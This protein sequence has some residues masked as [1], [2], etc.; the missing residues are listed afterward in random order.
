MEDWKYWLN[1]TNFWKIKIIY[2][3]A[4]FIQG[5]FLSQIFGLRTYNLTYNLLGGKLCRSFPE[6]DKV[7][8][9]DL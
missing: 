7:V 5:C 9:L 2:I 6:I 3:L 8:I 1:L 4:I